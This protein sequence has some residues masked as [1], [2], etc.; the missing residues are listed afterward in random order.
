LGVPVM[1]RMDGC[2]NSST[3]LSVSVG[4]LVAGAFLRGRSVRGTCCCCRRAFERP[5]L[6]RGSGR[7]SNN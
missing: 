1:G 4:M 3:I 5:E 6:S 7:I 2:G